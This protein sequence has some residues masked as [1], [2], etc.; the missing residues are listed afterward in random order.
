MAETIKLEYFSK[1][2]DNLLNSIHNNSVVIIPGNS[3]VPRNGDAHYRFRQDS[4]FYYLTGFTEPDSLAILLANGDERKFI[5]FVRPRDPAKEQW[6]GL[7]AGLE[8]AKCTYHAD[9]SYDIK[10][11][12]TVILEYIKNKSKIYYDLGSNEVYDHKV[13]F[14]LN[15]VKAMQRKGISAPDEIVNVDNI[16]AE[17]R[18][19]KDKYEQDLM[20]KAGRISAAAHIKAM[21]AA[22]GA[23]YEYQLEAELVYECVK[24]GAHS[25]AYNPIVG[26]GIN[27]CILHYGENNQLLDKSG[28]VLIDAGAEYHHYAADITRTFPANG[29]FSKNQKLIYELV[30]KAQLAALEEIKPGKTWDMAQ[31]VILK[32]ITSG[33]VELGI[34]RAN[35]KSTDELIKEEVYK[36]FYMHNS[37]H[38]LGIDVHDVGSYKIENKWRKLEP[39]MVLTVEPGI[40]IKPGILGVDS[41]WDNIGIR[42][43]DDILVTEYGHEVLTKDVPKQIH[44]IEELMAL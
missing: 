33:L 35:G 44:E 34:I 16:L 10:D 32:I 6:D 22:R 7:R 19:I 17:M 30:L 13:I 23:E 36:P 42:I 21:Q 28:L 27:T 31:K 15:S 41:K 9:E 18:L 37:G 38:W 25:Q 2:R 40:Y 12:D 1:R 29:K 26:G 20:R 14:W 39:G 5:L 43:E 3:E 4:N 11:L 24:H 8:G